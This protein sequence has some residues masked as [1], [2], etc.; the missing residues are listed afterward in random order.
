MRK[1]HFIPAV[2]LVLMLWLA[3]CQSTPQNPAEP[4]AAPGSTSSSEDAPNPETAATALPRTATLESAEGTVQWRASEAEAWQAAKIGQILEAGHQL[5]TG[6]ESRAALRF[7]EGALTRLGPNSAFT[8]TS[9]STDIHD[10]SAA[11]RLDSGNLFIILSGGSAEVETNSG[12][13]SVRGSYLNVRVPASGRTIVTC[14]EGQCSLATNAGEVALTNGQRSRAIDADLPPD[15]A[16]EMAALDYQFWFDEDDEAFWL[17]LE[18]E[19]LD[20]EDF[21]EEC[22]FETGEGCELE[23]PC[24][25]DTGDGCDLDEDFCEDYDADFCEDGEFDDDFD[26]DSD[27]FD[28]DD[29]DDDDGSDDDDH[30]GEDDSDDDGDDDDD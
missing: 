29:G 11:F 26:D 21:G 4:A 25:Y 30:G 1:G 7:T 9:M 18:L 14:L 17:A 13:A 27:E 12:V 23:D 22:D 15:E 3:A 20:E 24:D 5:T 2:I 28:D 6:A 16:E 19:L 8:L 10:P